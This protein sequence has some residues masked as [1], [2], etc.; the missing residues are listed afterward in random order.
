MRKLSNIA[1]KTVMN[2]VHRVGKLCGREQSLNPKSQGAEY[3]SLTHTRKF[4][5]W[6]QVTQG[7]TWSFR[8]ETESDRAVVHLRRT[9]PLCSPCASLRNFVKAKIRAPHGRLLPT[10]PK[11]LLDTPDLGKLIICDPNVR[12]NQEV[13]LDFIPRDA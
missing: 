8:T 9:L 2:A 1:S 10:F 7:G 6:W 5:P 13:T 3:L 11:A 4:A 12:E